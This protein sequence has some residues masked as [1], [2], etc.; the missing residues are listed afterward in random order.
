M[1]NL[2]QEFPWTSK[3]HSML[4]SNFVYKI[5]CKGV[6]GKSLDW[7]KSYLSGR[8]QIVDVNSFKSTQETIGTSISVLKGSILGPILFLVQ[9]ADLPSSSLLETFL[10]ADNTQE[11][12]A[13][14]N[15]PELIET[16]NLELEK[17]AQWFRSNKM[18]V[19]T[20]KN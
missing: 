4:A 14:G 12:K 2:V 16:V 9:S 18:S 17:W 20:R 19:N 8:N 7:F 1:A 15:L 11:L 6:T 3:R 13:G 10:F 5:K